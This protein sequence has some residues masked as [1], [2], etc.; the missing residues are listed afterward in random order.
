[1]HAKYFNNNH[2]FRPLVVKQAIKFVLRLKVFVKGA[3]LGKWKLLGVRNLTE[4]WDLNVRLLRFLKDFA[5]KW[6]FLIKNLRFQLLFLKFSLISLV[7]VS[8]IHEERKSYLFSSLISIFTITKFLVFKKPRAN[9]NLS[10]KRRPKR[11]TK[12]FSRKIFNGKT[13]PLREKIKEEIKTEKEKKLC[14]F[15]SRENRKI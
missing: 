14:G 10:A 12:N 6:N 1:M 4:T 11:K 3:E 8:N 15:V 9:E 7:L 13:L 5:S 2:F